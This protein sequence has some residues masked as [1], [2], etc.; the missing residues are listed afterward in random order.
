MIQTWNTTTIGTKKE[1]LLHHQQ[2]TGKQEGSLP[3]GSMSPLLR[4]HKVSVVPRAGS[5]AFQMYTHGPKAIG[6]RRA[7][8]PPERWVNGVSEGNQHVLETI[9]VQAIRNRE[10][11]VR[12]QLPNPGSVD[13]PTGHQIVFCMVLLLAMA[14]ALN[15]G[16]AAACIGPIEDSGNAVTMTGRTWMAAE[17]V[18]NRR[19][20]L[21]APQ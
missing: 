3:P 20:G 21:G 8:T 11:E 12:G 1:R 7:L 6:D 14:A 17:A 15:T 5:S 18:D 4:G 13:D 10:S 2:R 16:I 19:V 9:A